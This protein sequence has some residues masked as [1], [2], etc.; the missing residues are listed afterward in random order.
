M[1]AVTKANQELQIASPATG[2][3]GENDGLQGLKPCLG[4]GFDCPLI[5]DPRAVHLKKACIFFQMFRFPAAFELVS[6][7]A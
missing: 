1:T 3:T 7:P 6:N 4:C 2:Q 5:G